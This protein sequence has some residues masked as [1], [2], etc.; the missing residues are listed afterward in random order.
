MGFEGSS[1]GDG[2]STAAEQARWA[3][4]QA[5]RPVRVGDTI[6]RPAHHRSAYVG[7]LLLH[8]A[9]GG[10]T[11]AEVV[12]ALTARFHR[13]LDHHRAA[14][15]RGAVQVFDDLLTWMAR[16]GGQIAHG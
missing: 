15:L 14:G 6:R 3:E 16:C 8:L 13:A 1:R 12:E 11:A 10:I 7:A 9:A 2:M 5:A 4:R